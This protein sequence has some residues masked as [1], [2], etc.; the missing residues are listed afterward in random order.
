M[1]PAVDLDP[2]T[3]AFLYATDSG[4]LRIMHVDITEEDGGDTTYTVKRYSN[5]GL[6]QRNFGVVTT[7]YDGAYDWSAFRENE[8]PKAVAVLRRDNTI[9][10][11]H[12]TEY[13]KQF[14]HIDRFRSIN[15][16]EFFSELNQRT[17]ELRE[18]NYWSAGRTVYF[19]DDRYYLA[20][21][22]DTYDPDS[23]V[24]RPD[25]PPNRQSSYFL[26][27]DSEDTEQDNPEIIAT[28]LAG[29][30]A[31]RHAP[32]YWVSNFS[33]T[34]VFATANSRYFILWT[35]VRLSTGLSPYF[36]RFDGS[37]A[38]DPREAG[39]S[40]AYNRLPGQESFA[41]DPHPTRDSLIV[42]S[43]HNHRHKSTYVLELGSSSDQPLNVVAE[44]PFNAP[45]KQLN[46]PGFGWGEVNANARNWY[47]KFHPDGKKVAIIQ[48]I[49]GE[50][51]SVIIWNWQEEEVERRFTIGSGTDDVVEIRQ[52]AWLDEEDNSEHTNLLYF[53][54]KHE[55]DN[56]GNNENDNGDNGDEEITDR[57]YF[58]YIDIDDNTQSQ[59]RRIDWSEI[60]YREMSR[61]PEPHTPQNLKGRKRY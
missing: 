60:E 6:S 11:T 36:F 34:R 55:G 43:D 41:I 56:G 9:D 48:S 15:Q 39:G 44:L 30:Y 57:A 33:N 5:I 52:P 37:T 22:T 12:Q 7:E 32:N 27:Y 53:M 17:Q 31:S 19:I 38:Y 21:W 42:V 2:I 54:A 59:S 46:D 8:D 47:L 45:A 28:T 50:Q 16:M 26:L 49:D 51:P 61:D 40:Q 24:P 3:P 18:Y 1:E 14:A 23:G 25:L 20:Y 29:G 58:H 4:E 10:P 13:E 35:P